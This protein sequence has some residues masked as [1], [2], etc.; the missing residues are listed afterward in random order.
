MI[1]SRRPQLLKLVAVLQSLASADVEV[2]DMETFLIVK[3]RD[4]AQCGEYRT[5]R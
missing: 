4:E 3:R 5:K 1:P 2:G